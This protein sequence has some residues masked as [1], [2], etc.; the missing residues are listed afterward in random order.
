MEKSLL[1]GDYVIVS[2]L[3]YGPRL[4]ITP[5]SFPFVHQTLPFTNYTKSYLDW[6]HLPYIRLGGS[7]DVGKNDILVF[8]YPMDTD[9]PIDQRTYYIKRCVALPGDTLEVKQGLVYTN[10]NLTDLLENLQFNYKVFT[11]D[12]TLDT[13]SLNFLGITEGGMFGKKG[14]YGLTLTYEN[15][16]KLKN[17][18]EIKSIQPVMDKKGAYN[19]FMFPNSEHFLWNLDHYGKLYIPKSGDSVRLT[20][21]SL[22]LY[23]RIITV[24]EGNTLSINNDSVFINEK[25]VTHYTFKMNYY[26]MM[27]DNRHNSADSRFWGFLPE[28]HIVGKAVFVLMS[29]NKSD[30]NSH[31]RWERWFKSIN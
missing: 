6:F 28:D 2:K 3:S 27:G 31:L 17:K 7:P 18:K 25:Y 16:E 24:Y 13:D 8:N 23:E 20:K 12:D 10:G 4:P 9:N 5:L 19:D 1:T 21:D 11:G 26:F 29:V 22:P 14:E 30:G 15:L